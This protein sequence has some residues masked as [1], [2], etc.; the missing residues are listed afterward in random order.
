MLKG[1][2]ELDTVNVLGIPPLI[3]VLG[4]LLKFGDIRTRVEKDAMQYEPF[5]KPRMIRCKALK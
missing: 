5:F 1:A 3:V 2:V 4:M